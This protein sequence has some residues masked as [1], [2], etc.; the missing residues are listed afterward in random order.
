M[1]LGQ[2]IDCDY[3]PETRIRL[4]FFSTTKASR[5]KFRK[6]YLIRSESVLGEDARAESQR[7]GRAWGLVT[8]AGPL[9]GKAGRTL[10]I[11][12]VLRMSAVWAHLGSHPTFQ[13]A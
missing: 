2:L 1:L 8:L 6:S 12:G 4:N 3:R 5:L 7:F 11:W 9:I 13:Q 10:M